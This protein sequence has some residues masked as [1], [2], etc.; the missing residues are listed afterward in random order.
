[1]EAAT[2]CKSAWGQ[3]PILR[4]CP[5]HQRYYLY[6]LFL[7]KLLGKSVNSLSFYMG[8]SM[9]VFNLSPS[10]QSRGQ[11]NLECVT[12]VSVT[13]RPLYFKVALKEA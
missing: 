1:M 7:W 3:G 13:G 4:V 6:S 11:Q 5:R 2:I 9:E 10:K 8:L 12:E